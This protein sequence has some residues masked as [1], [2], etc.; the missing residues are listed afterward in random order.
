MEKEKREKWGRDWYQ[1][2]LGMS[3]PKCAKR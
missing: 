3:L 1:T 2:R